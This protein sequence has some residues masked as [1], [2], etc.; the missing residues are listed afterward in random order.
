MRRAVVALHC[1][2][3]VT[4][5]EEG[6]SVWGRLRSVF[7]FQQGS[8]PRKVYINTSKFVKTA[9]RNKTRYIATFSAYGNSSRSLIWSIPPLAHKVGALEGQRDTYLLRA[10]F[11]TSEVRHVRSMGEHVWKV[12]LTRTHCTICNSFFKISFRASSLDA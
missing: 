1:R 5:F 12:L 6:M 4:K 7:P 9:C 8:H 3:G 2:P 10:D 11:I